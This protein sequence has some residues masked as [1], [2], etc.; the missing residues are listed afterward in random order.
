MKLQTVLR[1]WGNSIG[2][3][4]PREIIEKE[5][6]REGEEV[7]IDIENKNDIKN[8]FGSLKDWRINSQKMKEELRRGWE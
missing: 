4:I 3:V 6:L 8:I 1:K 2:V 7:I 5:R